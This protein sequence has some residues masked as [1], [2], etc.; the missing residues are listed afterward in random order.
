VIALPGCQFRVET[1]N[2]SLISSAVTDLGPKWGVTIEKVSKRAKSDRQC[3]RD[4]AQCSCRRLF[5]LDKVLSV[6]YA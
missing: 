3:H 6:C 1:K 5:W 2:Q 4:W